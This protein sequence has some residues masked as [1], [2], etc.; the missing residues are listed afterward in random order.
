[1][2]FIVKDDLT[3]PLYPEV[4][5][6]ISRS[7]DQW[8]TEAIDSAIVEAKGYLSKYD[9]VKL[10]GTETEEPIVEEKYLNKIKRIIA[11]ISVWHLIKLS[12]AGVNLELYMKIYDDAVKYLMNIQKGVIDPEGWIYKTDDPETPGNENTS[13]QWSSNKKRIQHY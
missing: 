5:D 13:I 12:N 6:A 1:M 11:E 4:L 9:L 3:P 2:S 7:N 10:F 8:I